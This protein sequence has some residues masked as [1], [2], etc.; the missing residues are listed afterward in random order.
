[1]VGLS[2]LLLVGRLRK[3][4]TGRKV[5]LGRRKVKLGEESWEESHTGRKVMKVRLG[6]N[7]GRKV[8]QGGKSDWGGK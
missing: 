4:Q 2:R 3:C 1:M 8:I 7:A 5:R 6:R